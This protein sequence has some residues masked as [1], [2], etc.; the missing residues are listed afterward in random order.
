[1]CAKLCL[2]VSLTAQLCAASTASL[3]GA[4]ASNRNDTLSSQLL[5]KKGDP[6][7][8][9]QD[10]L[11]WRRGGESM[12]TV[13]LSEMKRNLTSLKDYV[14]QL[15]DEGT[16]IISLSTVYDSGLSPDPNEDVYIQYRLCRGLV[17]N[18]LEKPSKYFCDWQEATD[19][20]VGDY[21]C[22][23]DT[24]AL[25]QGLKDLIAH[26]HSKRDPP[27]K[28]VSWMNPS[29]V[30]SGSDYYT[31]AQRDVNVA[32]K[33]AEQQGEGQKWFDYLDSDSK[34]RWFGWDEGKG[35]VY[36]QQDQSDCSRDARC[37]QL[38]PRNMFEDVS[39]AKFYDNTNTGYNSPYP[40][41]TKVST[42][43]G[44]ETHNCGIDPPSVW[45]TETELCVDSAWA[46]QPTGKFS[47]PEWAEYV[48]GALEKWVFEYGLDGFVLDAPDHYVF[49]DDKGKN[50]FRDMLKSI[51]ERSQ[52]T[53]PFFAE[54][55]REPEFAAENRIDVPLDGYWY[56]QMYDLID[57]SGTP[58][59]LGTMERFYQGVD[60][61]MGQ[62][63]YKGAWCPVGWQRVAVKYTKDRHLSTQN[64]LAMALTAAGGFIPAVESINGGEYYNSDIN[65][66]GQDSQAIQ[67]AFS[68]AGN[69]F[70]NNQKAT[71]APAAEPLQDDRV[72]ALVRYDA[73]ETGEVGVFAA[74]IGGKHAQFEPKTAFTPAVL[75]CFG[76]FPQE[77]PWVLDTN[78]WGLTGGG[79]LPQWEQVGV[80]ANCYYGAGVIDGY[81]P[82]EPAT[83]I[84]TD[85]MTFGACLLTCLEH[86]ADGCRS[87]TVKFLGDDAAGWVNCWLRG[88][89]DGGK[90]DMTCTDCGFTAY[91]IKKDSQ[92]AIC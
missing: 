73:L 18:D 68:N 63:F 77:Q 91:T 76:G 17:I 79:I 83:Y 67:K 6:W 12:R 59:V 38:A 20:N 54:I 9:A 41:C 28:I 42:C 88:E 37:Y 11:W 4:I 19:D 39:D 29:Y 10:P 22:T 55:Y 24:N 87:V 56:T 26:V 50:A 14:N 33:E 21:S 3:R 78:T 66:D 52:W 51:Q 74:N 25:I 1:M 57:D 85:V 35:R 69:A 36:C 58:D 90:C 62:C 84:G 80:D 15:H 40:E 47:N 5:A 61:T 82:N 7:V 48:R 31:E 2:V 75:K 16:T 44:K 70:M 13:A 46:N 45:D 71:R 8:P 64:D 81:A 89:V 60:R 72:Y 32:R 23:S 43:I 53:V 92:P 65:F 27:M 86:S 30:W 34:A 49:Q